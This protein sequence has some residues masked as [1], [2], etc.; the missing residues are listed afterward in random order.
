MPRKRRPPGPGDYQSAYTGDLSG[1]QKQMVALTHGLASDSDVMSHE[2]SV[3]RLAFEFVD[4]G[5]SVITNP[6]ETE[7][8]STSFS[9]HILE[10]P[11]DL[12]THASV[13]DEGQIVFENL[14]PERKN[15]D[16]AIDKHIGR[17]RYAEA[18]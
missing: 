11:I 6:S 12:R 2:K 5:R 7:D 13:L 9:E 1:D 10:F 14:P 15:N 18:D 8:T 4:E 16:D 3:Q 17:Q